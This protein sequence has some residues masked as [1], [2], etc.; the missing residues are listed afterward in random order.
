MNKKIKRLQVR[1]K[2]QLTNYK[3]RLK[4]SGIKKNK[5]S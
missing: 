4:N 5:S 2:K 3:N 1:K